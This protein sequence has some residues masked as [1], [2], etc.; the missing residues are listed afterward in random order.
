[1]RQ[2]LIVFIFEVT[3]C[4][5]CRSPAVPLPGVNIDPD[6][7]C[8][9][10]VSRSCE[11]GGLTIQ[12]PNCSDKNHLA[13]AECFVET[14]LD[15]IRNNDLHWSSSS[16]R[17]TVRH[18]KSRCSYLRQRPN[19]VAIISIRFPAGEVLVQHVARCI[20]SQMVVGLMV[21]FL[22]FVGLC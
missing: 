10:C 18:F 7:T 22:L 8:H 15:C 6:F 4:H 21:C 5:E 1:M 13:C 19:F 12:I 14:M 16:E 9:L 3:V 11:E 20:S 2:Y 17:F